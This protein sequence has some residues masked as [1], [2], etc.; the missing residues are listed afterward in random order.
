MIKNV[1]FIEGADNVGKTTSIEYLRYNNVFNTEFIPIIFKHYPSSLLK[2]C[3][4]SS[5]NSLRIATIN[6]D[7]KEMMRLINNIINDNINDM[8]Y[9]FKSTGSYNDTYSKNNTKII[10][11]CDRGALSTYLYNYKSLIELK[12]MVISE[13]A[14]LSEFINNYIEKDDNTKLHTIIFN[15]NHPNIELPKE[16]I[17]ENG[18][19]KDID[20]NVSL[21]NR[22]N[23]SIS[24]II[25]LIDNNSIDNNI[26]TFHYINI[27]PINSNERKSL[28]EINLEIHKIITDNI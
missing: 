25:N 7:K 4:D 16:N 27:Y 6:N 10:E 21:Q 22:I 24:N 5:F 13:K 2:A 15:N 23:T 3:L 20:N 8:K 14:C 26:M 19:K 9:S 1:F 28:E 11:I 18:Y 17:I 12:N